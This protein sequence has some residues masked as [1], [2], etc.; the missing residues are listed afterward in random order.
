MNK[1][2]IITGNFR[3]IIANLSEGSRHKQNLLARENI[4]PDGK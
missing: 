1:P 4:T 3:K 2:P